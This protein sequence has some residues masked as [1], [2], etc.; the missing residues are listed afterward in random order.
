M[1]GARLCSGEHTR[2]TEKEKTRSVAWPAHSLSSGKRALEVSRI[3]GLSPPEERRAP[4]SA[5]CCVTEV[6]ICQ[7][8]HG[9]C[10]IASSPSCEALNERIHVDDGP[11]VLGA[12]CVR[13]YAQ[14]LRAV[15]MFVW[16]ALMCMS[17][18]V[19]GIAH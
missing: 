6:L 7:L 15:V 16:L 9:R 11:R 14:E 10:R 8:Q 17:V 19:Y 12:L 2:S 3:L 5:L 4:H 1:A 18:D 13:A